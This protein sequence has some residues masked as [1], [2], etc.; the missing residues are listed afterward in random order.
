M[1]PKIAKKGTSFK[2]AGAYYLH[3]KK[4]DT[5]ERV[6]FTHTL[7]LATDNPALAIKMMA[8]TAMHQQQLKAA[9]DDVV[10]TGRK[11]KSP[12]YCYSLAWAPEETPTQTEMID[13]ARQT[14]DKLGLSE[15]EVLLVAHNDEPHKHIHVIVNRVHPET[16]LAAKLKLDR[17]KLS[18][19]AEKYEKAQGEIRCDQ[20]VENNKRRK[21]GEFVKYNKNIE[22]GEFH[23]WKKEKLKQAFDLKNLN[24]K[25]LKAEQRG[26]LNF[27]YDEKEKRI[28]YRRSEIKEDYRS[29]WSRL[30][31]DQW[32]DIRDLR[33]ANQTAIK[34]FRYWLSHRERWEKAGFINTFRS[35]LSKNTFAHRF[36][37]LHEKQRRNLGNVQREEIRQAIAHENQWYR[38]EIKNI[39]GLQQ[40][41]IDDLE[42]Q[43]DQE[44]ENLK[45]A[46]DSPE[47]EQAYKEARPLDVS[48]EFRKRAE[49]IRKRRKRRDERDRGKGKDRGRD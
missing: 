42:K 25:A 31:K 36:D 10:A 5:S 14:L 48:E 30:Y 41:Q 26:G 7:N 17:L 2:G 12:V 39:K 35:I 1:V 16:G 20:R 4:A 47:G 33:Q 6:E 28:N 3:D 45:D 9:N 23:R 32:K 37:Q 34:R 29:K 44:I 38:D 24:I 46:L 13:A 27:L 21:Q 40:H 19:W 49:R 43:Y 22:K 11:L 15:H 8:Y 18:T